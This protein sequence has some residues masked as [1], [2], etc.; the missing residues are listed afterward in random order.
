MP[1]PDTRFTVSEAEL[2]F[3]DF[4]FPWKRVITEIRNPAHRVT[5]RKLADKHIP[6]IHPG[7]WTS[8]RL[9]KWDEFGSNKPEY[10]RRAYLL[11]CLIQ[12][13][14]WDVHVVARVL[15]QAD[16]FDVQVECDEIT[17]AALWRKSGMSIECLECEA[18]GMGSSVDELLP[19]VPKDFS[20]RVNPLRRPV[21]TPDV[22][23]E[24]D[25]ILVESV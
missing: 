25:E 10:R 20:G 5:L 22:Q 9:V 1:N 14:L 2:W 17:R 15:E 11:A 21:N 4:A 7:V 18:R 8:L 19:W 23:N 3:L 12:F 13:W 24:I 16:G 6:R